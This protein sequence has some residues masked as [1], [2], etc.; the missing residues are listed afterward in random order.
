M[1]PVF[2]TPGSRIPPRRSRRESG[3]ALVE[4]ALA[5][6]LLVVMVVGTLD[7]GR[8]F[9]T[10]MVLTNAARAGAQYGALNL[11]KSGDF[12]GMQSAATTVLTANGLGSTPTPTTTRTC[13]CVPAAG[14]FGAAVAC[15]STCG[16]GEQLVT[17]VNVSVQRT[18]SM[19]SPY[20]GLPGSVTMTR[21]HTMRVQ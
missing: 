14:T 18:F 1:E 15:T 13:Y 17:T 21:M 16:A 6:P 4:L 8:A 9:R 3:A 12:T 10:A 7:F 2:V 19:I 11:G 20:P 5:L